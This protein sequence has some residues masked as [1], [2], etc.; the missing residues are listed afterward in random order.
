MPFYQNSEFKEG[1]EI[2]KQG[3][4]RHYL[5]INPD[6]LRMIA[7]VLLGYHTDSTR[8]MAKFALEVARMKEK[9]AG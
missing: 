8:G 2:A 1:Y 4:Y 5:Q 6:E 9:A 3:Y 7:R